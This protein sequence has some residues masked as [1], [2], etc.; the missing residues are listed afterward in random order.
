MTI[1]THDDGTGARVHVAYE[2][3]YPWDDG[4]LE[5]AGRGEDGWKVYRGAVR[6]EYLC[7]DLL[8][9]WDAATG[10]RLVP[11]PTYEPT[12]TEKL[13]A[14]MGEL[15]ARIDELDRKA[16]RAMRAD[17]AGTATEEDAT[18]LAE[19][20]AQVQAARARINEIREILEMEAQDGLEADIR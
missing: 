7:G 11:I 1:I 12:E 5:K 2:G 15:Q 19:N 8:A 17:R 9:E 3:P 16:I 4:A 20:E 6:A 14:E 18:Y 13:N 10:T